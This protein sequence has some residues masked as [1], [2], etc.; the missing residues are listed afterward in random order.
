MN[1]FLRQHCL[2]ALILLMQYPAEAAAQNISGNSNDLN[3]IRLIKIRRMSES[4]INRSVELK[5]NSGKTV[6]GNFLPMR[7]GMFR[8]E[9]SGDIKEISAVDIHSVVLKRRPQEL[10]L[11]GILGLGAGALFA[12]IGSLGFDAEGSKLIT[13]AAIGTGAGF[14]FGWQTFYKNIVVRLK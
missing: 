4:W 7:D 8:L 3:Q 14:S 10:L 5:S 11:V 6:A 13:F 1:L 2:L 9:V 12:G